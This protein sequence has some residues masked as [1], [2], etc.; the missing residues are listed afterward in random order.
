MDFD[1]RELIQ[2]K[3]FNTLLTSLL[4]SLIQGDFLIDN[5]ESS[6]IIHL[7][8]KEELKAILELLSLKMTDVSLSAGEIEQ[9][10]SLVYVLNTYI[11]FIEKIG[12]NTLALF[13]GSAQDPH[14][15]KSEMLNSDFLKNIKNNR[16]GEFELTVELFNA[17]V[18]LFEIDEFI[19]C[20]D[21]LSDSLE[22]L[23]EWFIKIPIS[24]FSEDFILKF[25]ITYD[26]CKF[27]HNKINYRTWVRDKRKISD[28][29]S[30]S[31]PEFQNK[32]FTKLWSEITTHYDCQS[33]S[34]L[35]S[36]I[37]TDKTTVS[38]YH[39]FSKYLKKNNTGSFKERIKR[40]DLLKSEFQENSPSCFFTKFSTH[41]LLVA[42]KLKL[43]LDQE[44]EEFEF[45]N[46]LKEY[47]NSR[48]GEISFLEI[49]KE[50]LKLKEFEEGAIIKK[51]SDY[52][53]HFRLLLFI[54]DFLNYLRQ[55]ASLWL[56]EIYKKDNEDIQDKERIRFIVKKE[57]DKLEWIKN[58]YQQVYNDAMENLKMHSKYKLLPVYLDIKSVKYQVDGNQIVFVDSGYILPSSFIGFDRDWLGKESYVDSA[59][60]SL[61]NRIELELQFIAFNLTKGDFDKRVKENEFKVIQIVALFVSVSVF[62]LGTLKTLDNKNLYES[63]AIVSLLAGGLTLF[64]A[65][66]RWLVIA[67]IRRPINFGTYKDFGEKLYEFFFLEIIKN[68]WIYFGFFYLLLTVV[69]FVLYKCLPQAFPYFQLIFLVPL[70]FIFLIRFPKFLF[71]ISSKIFQPHTIYSVVMMFIIGAFIWM[72]IFFL[73][74]SNSDYDSKFEN[75]NRKIDSLDLAK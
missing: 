20:S 30:F 7:D 43:K 4:A 67:Q 28:F 53:G 18:F 50:E 75:L 9:I 22:N 47:L 59:V 44:K 38:Y 27:L 55:N 46:V 72:S 8:Y 21:L 51:M 57:K 41:N 6:K 36:L 73:G 74:K 3:H 16:V 13:S 15:L 60:R 11:R 62:A 68:Y 1:Y 71:F 26:K 45:E 58:F 34:E 12:S 56:S 14:S 19:E 63:L 33:I 24:N 64:N 66:F 54:E 52:H 32:V 10:E 23:E 25:N 31:E 39:H 37:G 40:I 2:E 61:C 69:C 35:R 42:T 65:F 49:C 29:P 17:N 48:N 70:F 5:P